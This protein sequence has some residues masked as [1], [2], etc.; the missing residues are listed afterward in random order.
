MQFADIP[1]L[2]ELKHQ[3]VN[4][5][6]RGKVA[7]GQLFAGNEGTATLPM[8]IAYVS[9]LFCENKT[10]EDSCGTCPN[11]Q[12]IQKAIHP[13]VHWY[14]PKISAS[15][16]GKYEKVLGE[17]LPAWRSFVAETPYGGLEDWANT[18]GQENKNLQLSRQD[19]RQ[20]LKNVSM[21]S[22]EGGYKVLII[23]GAEFM[24]P[25]AANALLKVLEE[26]PANTIFLLISFSYDTLLRTITSRTQLVTVPPN[27]Q[28]ELE[29]YFLEK[30]DFGEQ[31]VKHLAKLSQGKIGVARRLLHEDQNVSYIHF[32]DW[33]LSCWNRDLTQLVR[34]SEEFSKS[35]KSNQR[36]FLV[37]AISLIR[38]ALLQLA[39]NAGNSVSQEEEGFVQKF[40]SRLGQEK[41]EF[42]YN[43]LND[44]INHLDRN[45][46]PRITH[47]NLSL[48]ILRKIN[49]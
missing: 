17:A 2:H 9:Y 14:F 33:M 31:K 36:S 7:H 1:G 23:W 5:F 34:S 11:C 4:A 27:S 43:S 25:S 21:R 19:S 30:N 26:P 45:A 41:L 37:Y 13:D 46:N 47:L 28:E 29:S 38:N 39:G 20:V 35:G 10:E 6:Q 22:V 8:A 49:G 32:R 12:R 16:S 48:A 42:M 44:S 15:D 3:L 24:H 18:Y 40:A